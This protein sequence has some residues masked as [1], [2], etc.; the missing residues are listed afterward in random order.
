M[1]DIFELRL[2]SGK[3]LE[4]NKK[5]HEIGVIAMGS[6]L[7]NHGSALPID[8]DIKIASYVAFNVALKTGVKFLG[9]VCT[10]TEYD[11][12]KHGIHNSLEDI[13]S[14]LEDIIIKYSKIGINKLLIINCHGGNSDISK[15]ID[16]LK[17]NIKKR[18][19]NSYSKELDM[20]SDV[21][22]DLEYLKKIK[23][24]FKD[25]G[26]IEKLKIDVKS[27]GY[28]HAYSEELSIGKYIG[29]YEEKKMNK[30]NPLNYEEIGMVG[31]VEARQNNKY[32]NEE[33]EMVENKPA[34]VDANYGKELTDKMIK[35][36]IYCIK[37]FLKE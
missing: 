29:I 20:D 33:A 5:V 7:E 28:I 10:S 34:I 2:N 23:H 26:N 31:L 18:L 17:D 30:H 16:F 25:Y 35:E 19:E 15:K 3:L 14:E 1:S 22:V 8:T 13:I 32:I 21:D 11:Y 36:S 4:E 9:T 12:V 37:E 24:N 6:Y 27:F